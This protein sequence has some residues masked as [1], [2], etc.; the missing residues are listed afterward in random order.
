MAIWSEILTMD[1]DVNSFPDYFPEAMTFLEKHE[2]EGYEDNKNDKGGP[3]NDGISL[4]FMLENGLI[5][6]DNDK[7]GRLD[8]PDIKELTD[9]QIHQIY[10]EDFWNKG[11]MYRIKNKQIA[12]K[13]FDMSVNTGLRTGVKIL[14]KAIN[15]LPPHPG[16]QED[17]ILGN[18][19]VSYLDS[20]T[21]DYIRETLLPTYRVECWHYYERI[22]ENDPSQKVFRD[23]WEK[24]A[25]S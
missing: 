1:L 25:Y 9:S 14:Q 18:V 20:K 7:D 4:R 11:N 24:R 12:L 2:G 6:F 23:G 10:R 19:T 22:I 5:K 3:T 16:I 13:V 15:V 8:A 17:G 21:D